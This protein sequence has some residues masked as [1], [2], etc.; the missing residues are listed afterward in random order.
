MKALYGTKQ[1]ARL[2]R[3]L[4]HKHMI[5]EMMIPSKIMECVYM[6]MKA[7]APYDKE[8]EHL[9]GIRSISIVTDDLASLHDETGVGANNYQAF[10]DRFL[11]KFPGTDMGDIT[12]YCSLNIE[13]GPDGIYSYDHCKYIEGMLAKQGL[14]DIP[15]QDMPYSETVIKDL[16]AYTKTP[17]E[18]KLGELVNLTAYRS[19]IGALQYPAQNTTPAA[20]A[21]A[22]V[23]ATYMCEGHVRQKH[24]DAAM[25][26]AGYMKKHRNDKVR[27]DPGDM[28]I[29]GGA[30]A[31]FA[32]CRR[33]RR[34]RT[35]LWT[36]IGKSLIN[37]KSYM[38]NG[39]A[40]APSDA[41]VRAASD[42]AKEIRFIRLH[43]AEYGY[44]MEEPAKLEC[45]CKPAVAIINGS[46]PMSSLR[47][48]DVDAR[49]A[50][51]AREQKIV[52]MV[53]VDTDDNTADMLTKATL[54]K[55][56][57]HK[58]RRRLQGQTEW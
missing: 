30:D 42:A 9:R 54:T 45:D 34:S 12:Y 49:F 48:L 55:E 19:I 27:M 52:R 29:R 37:F 50:Q 35:G 17:D 7:D 58:F 11:A 32:A 1:G 3:E 47:Y 15:E 24:M 44:E 46:G 40:K 26:L 31:S 4:V 51:E 33:T 10:V 13:R 43:M 25:H 39:T 38:Q 21:T 53:D 22:G 2:W 16:N 36:R 56:K 5:E 18:Y 41:E 28:Q 20:T 14:E 23:L 6:G 57:L 8:R